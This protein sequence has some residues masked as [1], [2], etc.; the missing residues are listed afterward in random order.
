V[1]I[2]NREDAVEVDVGEIEETACDRSGGMPTQTP[3]SD[4]DGVR[5]VDGGWPGPR[6]VPGGDGEVNVQ[7]RYVGAAG[8]EGAPVARSA[9]SGN[10]VMDTVFSA[11]MQVF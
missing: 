6:P 9:D 11:H 2:R 7:R 5:E 4:S 8:L 1:D 10:T 3:I